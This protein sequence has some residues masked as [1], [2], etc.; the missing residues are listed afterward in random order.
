MKQMLTVA[1]GVFFAIGIMSFIFGGWTFLEKAKF[2]NELA[3]RD[4]TNKF[5]SQVAG[6]DLLNKRE[7]ELKQNIMISSF[8]AA[9]ISSSIGVGLAVA[10]KTK[11]PE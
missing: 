9:G 6:L 2:E 8:V 11:A 5:I 10:G 4:Q 1:G 3:S 7:L